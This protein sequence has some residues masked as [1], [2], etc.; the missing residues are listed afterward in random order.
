MTKTAFTDPELQSGFESAV[1]KWRAANRDLVDGFEQEVANRSFRAVHELRQI[2]KV[3]DVH[4][5]Y[6]TLSRIHEILFDLKERKIRWTEPL[7]KA[8]HA[9][10]EEIETWFVEGVSEKDEIISRIED[11]VTLRSYINQRSDEEIKLPLEEE[12]VENGLIT[13]VQLDHA[14]QLASRS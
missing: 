13:K 10:D 6:A 8:I 3:L 7:V 5:L 1:K 9:A 14:Q 4:N 12:L 11:N 2:S